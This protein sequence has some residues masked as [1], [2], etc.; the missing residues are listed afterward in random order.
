MR[1]KLKRTITKTE[2]HNS[3]RDLA[4]SWRE[5]LTW[6]RL[7]LLSCP[8][9]IRRPDPVYRN[10]QRLIDE[11]VRVTTAELQAQQSKIPAARLLRKLVRDALKNVRRLRT[12]WTAPCSGAI[13]ASPI[14]GSP[15]MS[16]GVWRTKPLNISKFVKRR[17]SCKKMYLSLKCKPASH[18]RQSLRTE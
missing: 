7:N 13:R 16:F 18:R 3:F 2:G 14:G 1:K 9:I 6:L 5:F 11:M 17:I 10:R 4:S 12:P 8:C 15:S